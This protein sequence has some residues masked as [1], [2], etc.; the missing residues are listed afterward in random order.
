M[1]R[2][3]VRKSPKTDERGNIVGT[4]YLY[5]ALDDDQRADIAKTIPEATI[6]QRGQLVEVYV[7][8]I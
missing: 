2:S 7:P 5:E 4:R 1:L 8:L 3:P 6:Q